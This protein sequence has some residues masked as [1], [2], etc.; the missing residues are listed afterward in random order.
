MAKAKKKRSTP[1][2]RKVS[3]KSKTMSTP[4]KKKRKSPARRRTALAKSSRSP[5]RRRKRKT[6]LGASTSELKANAVNNGIA[7]AG[8]AAYGIGIDMIKV[9]NPWAKAGIG[10]GAAL[11]FGFLGMRNVSAGVA[12]AAG[13]DLGR[14]MFSK[15]G[16]N[17]GM[18]N[19]EYVDPHTLSDSGLE[20]EHGNAIIKDRRGICYQ[21]GSDGAL[22]EMGDIYSLS[23]S[24]GQDMH[25]NALINLDDDDYS[26]SSNPYNLASGW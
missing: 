13:S 18:E 14:A 21:Q 16:L 1:H 9:Q 12:G 3:S 26:L 7:F 2:K 5:I 25:N 22:H 23:A 19:V 15:I 4:K 17:D 20:D 11:G 6:L 8:G 10:A 24:A